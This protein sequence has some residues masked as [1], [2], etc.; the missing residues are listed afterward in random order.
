MSSDSSYP[1]DICVLL[2][3]HGEHRWLTSE[4]LPVLH[5][6]ES[7]EDICEDELGAALAYLEVLWLDACRRAAETEAALE[8]LLG[9]D[10]RTRGDLYRHARSYHAAVRS[11]RRELAARVRDATEG[12]GPRTTHLHAA[13]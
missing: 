5:Q 12:R 3:A 7:G 2:R 1:S 13:L 9:E 10:P 11:L 6:V 8:A 4:V